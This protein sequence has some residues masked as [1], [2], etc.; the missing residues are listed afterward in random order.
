MDPN[1]RDVAK[2]LLNKDRAFGIPYKVGPRPA[3]SC[4][5]RA[6]GARKSQHCSRRRARGAATG[7]VCSRPCLTL[8]TPGAP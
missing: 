8:L 5:A 6:F 2:N 4:A 3:G 1:D 7:G